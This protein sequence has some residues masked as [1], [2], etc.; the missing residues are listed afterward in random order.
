MC[1]L[2]E[3]YGRT[4]VV[5]LSGICKTHVFFAENHGP[6]DMTHFPL[7]GPGSRGKSLYVSMFFMSESSACVA[8]FHD[9]PVW[10]PESERLGICEDHFLNFKP[11]LDWKDGE[12]QNWREH[13]NRNPLCWGNHGF[14][15]NV[16]LWRIQRESGWHCDKCVSLLYP[17]TCKH[18]RRQSVAPTSSLSSAQKHI[19]RWQLVQ[20]GAPQL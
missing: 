10:L 3:F 4:H 20:G 11:K 16:P 17:T 18:P 13:G 14:L 19:E 7:P 12:S 9:H 2:S 8:N 15:H 6:W 5:W 1:G